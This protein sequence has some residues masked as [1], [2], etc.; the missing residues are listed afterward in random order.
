MHRIALAVFTASLAVPALAANVSAFKEA[1][2]SR[3]NAAEVKE[4][5]GFVEKTLD[6]GKEGSTAEWKAPKTTFTSKVTMGKSFADGKLKCREATIDS[7]SHDRQ[8]RGLYTF[9]K[10]D[11]GGWNFKIPDKKSK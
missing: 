11:K 7:D 9:C 1:P 6:E 10:G 5:W 2:V 4:F 3:L 8:M